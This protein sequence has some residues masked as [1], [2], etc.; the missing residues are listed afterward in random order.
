MEAYSIKLMSSLDVLLFCAFYSC[1]HYTFSSNTTRS[2]VFGK[3]REGKFICISHFNRKAI[4]S[5]LQNIKNNIS[6]RTKA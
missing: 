2:N 3:A 6:K 4:Q 5:A 1:S